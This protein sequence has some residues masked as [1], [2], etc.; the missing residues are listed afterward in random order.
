M[1]MDAKSLPDAG[2]GEEQQHRCENAAEIQMNGAQFFHNARC[3]LRQKLSRAAQTVNCECKTESV[4]GVGSSG[5][6]LGKG[7]IEHGARCC[8]NCSNGLQ[9]C[10]DELAASTTPIKS[11]KSTRLQV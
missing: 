11:R 3:C 5:I 4:I 1:K 2:Y 8:F 9:K 7:F 6:L 10:V